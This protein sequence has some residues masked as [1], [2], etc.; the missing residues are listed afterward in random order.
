MENM[1]NCFKD[2]KCIK[3]ACKKSC[4]TLWQIEVDK[5]TLKKYKKVKGEFKSRIEGGINFHTSSLCVNKGRCAFL[6]SDNLCD[7][8]IN[9]GEEYLSEVCAIHPRFINKFKNYTE[10]GVGISCEEGARLLLSFNGEIKPSA[11]PS[12]KKLKGFE[13]DIFLFREKVLSILYNGASLKNRIVNILELLSI[14]ENDFLSLPFTKILSSMEILDSSWKDKLSLFSSLSYPVEEQDKFTNLLAYFIYRHLITALDNLDLKSKTLFALFSTLA[15]HNIY[16]NGK[17]KE[18]NFS[19][20][21][22]ARDYSGEIEYS[23]ENLYR[24]FDFFEEFI[25]KQEIKK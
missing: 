1:L 11:P 19:L 4:C 21:E 6:N 5:K 14:N 23:K 25:I 2:F 20:L 13:K 12:V 17:L 3:G 22:I 7:I 16:M 18:V 24:L 10:M 9:L 8:I 15:I